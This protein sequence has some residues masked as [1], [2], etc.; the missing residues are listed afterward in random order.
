MASAAGG[1]EASPR[2]AQVELNA[3]E[4]DKRAL[5]KNGLGIGGR[6][7]KSSLNPLIRAKERVIRVVYI[8]LKGWGGNARKEA[9][10]SSVPRICWWTF[11]L[12]N[13]GGFTRKYKYPVRSL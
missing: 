13:G 4:R 6:I 2:E 1:K 8:F 9:L 11:F 3:Y 12:L 10:S 7:R 5:E